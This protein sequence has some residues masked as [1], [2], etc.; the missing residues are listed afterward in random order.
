MRPLRRFATMYR[1]RPDHDAM[2]R[3]CVP[4]VLVANHDGN[5]LDWLQALLDDEG[6]H[7]VTAIDSCA[8]LA[9]ARDFRPDLAVLDWRLPPL[10][11]P[12]VARRIRAADAIPVLML[13]TR[14]TVE[15]RV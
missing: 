8:A 15:T 4:T 2:G 13:A 11:G 6:L 9:Q 7:V 10:D 3:M 1:F 14:D 12:E 5:L